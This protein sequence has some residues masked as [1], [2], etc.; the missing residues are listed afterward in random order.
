MFR[1][2][3]LFKKKGLFCLRY[4]YDIF[5]NEIVLLKIKESQSDNKPASIHLPKQYAASLQF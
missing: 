1:V 5:I 3:S 2:H 4:I